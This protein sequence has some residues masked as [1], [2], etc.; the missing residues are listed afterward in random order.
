MLT[1][2]SAKV[3]TL[4]QNGTAVGDNDDAVELRCMLLASVLAWCEFHRQRIVR[5]IEIVE[6]ER[7]HCSSHSR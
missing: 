2:L 6:F 4:K 3:K 5:H 7:N 1:D